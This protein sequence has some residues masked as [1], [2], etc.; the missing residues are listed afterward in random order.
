LDVKILDLT[1]LAEAVAQCGAE[2]ALHQTQFRW[3]Q[4]VSPCA[5]A[6]RL[7]ATAT[8]DGTFGWMG[9]PYEVGVVP[10]KD[11]LGYELQYDT[12]GAGQWIADRFGGQALTKLKDEYGASVATRALARKGYAITKQRNALG[13]LQV[14]AVRR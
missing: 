2:L 3:Y 7:P 14:V 4:G 6:I 9:K 5:H 1:A 10:A 12:Y 8:T 13:E 11:G